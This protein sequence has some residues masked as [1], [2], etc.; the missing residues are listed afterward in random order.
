M[1]E[2][3]IVFDH[4]GKKFRRG[5]RATSVRDLIVNVP[6]RLAGLSEKRRGGDTFWALEDIS[7]EVKEGEC[8]GI[9]GPN[10]A[11]KST[12][13]KLAS[14]ILRP[15]AGSVMVNGRVSTL[16]E[17][18]AGFSWELT[19][20]ENIIVNGAIL[21][22]T[23]DEIEERTPEI[24]DFSE[25][26]D[27][28]LNTPLKY[29]S[30]G[31][32]LRLGFSVAVYTKPDILLVDEI[33]AVGDMSFRL[34]CNEKMS[35]IRREGVTIV[36]VSHDLGLIRHMC[37]RA[38][39]LNLG[40]QIGPDNSGAIVDMYQEAV[41][42]EARAKLEAKVTG[43]T[44]AARAAS[45]RA[46]IVNARWYNPE[47]GS[48]SGV[49]TGHPLVIEVGYSCPAPVANPSFQ[50]AFAD[51]SLENITGCMTK[52]S[53]V[54]IPELRGEGSFRLTIPV[55]G[56]AAGCYPLKLTLFD[57]LGQICANSS[58]EYVLDVR[59]GEFISGR[60][61]FYQ[62]HQ[63]QHLPGVLEDMDFIRECPR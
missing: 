16:I 47:T 15:N 41:R 48:A 17:L 8:F 55:V 61:L 5:E 31:M 9:V 30:S 11:G 63:W 27:A 42:A 28:A 10:G 25:L 21:G 20:Y 56:L 58:C 51:Q 46:K 37:D 45:S 14:N 35:E 54:E 40:H 34:K 44:A 52:M 1:S 3:S 59:P 22:L 50:I 62:S 60:A 53:G 19:G 2:Y 26:D 39:A 4:V 12:I 6:R 24:V 43:E 57:E 32:F 36:L 23:K 29:Y 13:L 7:F 49:R 33:L 18:G 38:L